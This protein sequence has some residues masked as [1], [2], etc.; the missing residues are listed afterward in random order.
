MKEFRHFL[1][2]IATFIMAAASCQQAPFLTMNSPKSFN[3][4]KDGGSQTFTF[5]TNK[6][7]KVSSSE[8]W[9][10]VSPSSGNAAEGN[11]TVTITAEKNNGY[12]SRS[13][14]LTVNVEDLSQTVEI[15]QSFSEEIIVDEKQVNVSWKPEKVIVNVQTNTDFEVDVPDPSWCTAERLST[16]GLT[17]AQISLSIKA[18]VGFSPRTQ[19]LTIKQKNGSIER[20]VSIN[21]G[22]QEEL[23]DMGLSV[24]WRSY[25][26]G[27]TNVIERGD[28]YAWGET[29]T[30][31]QYLEANYKWYK[32][33]DIK[34]VIKYNIANNPYIGEPEPDGKYILEPED[35]I[36]ALS[37]G[38]NWRMP[39]FFEALELANN[40]SCEFVENYYE[41]G[42]PGI[43]VTSRIEGYEE[44]SIF[45][46]L[47]G[48]YGKTLKHEDRE[49]QIWL[50]TQ[51]VKMA[52]L[53]KVLFGHISRTFLVV[54]GD[55]RDLGA[56]IRPIYDDK[57]HTLGIRINEN[58]YI[59]LLEGYDFQLSTSIYP[60][61][62]TDNAV[63]WSSAD[64]SIA[65]VNQ[66]GLVS[67]ISPGTV[68]ITASVSNGV[69][70]QRTFNIM[71]KQKEEYVDMGLSV[72]WATCNLGAD[73]FEKNGDY[74]SWG[75]TTPKSYYGWDNYAWG[76]Q[77]NDMTY[78]L[79]KYLTKEKYGS[80]DNLVQLQSQDD[81][82][83]TT[84]GNGWRMPTNKE[85]QELIDNSYVY[86][87]YNYYNT[88]IN[89]YSVVSKVEG[90]EDKSLFFPCAGYAIRDGHYLDDAS[91]LAATLDVDKNERAMTMDFYWPKLRS[92]VRSWGWPIRPVKNK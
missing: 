38:N 51:D 59:G 84:L 61:D 16:K 71:P 28:Y 39:T 18:N 3:F 75:E 83:V 6:D 54:G 43:I 53:A 77:N 29:E 45:F 91:Y 64:E 63:K 11:V 19:I 85:F 70:D 7:W 60:I 79:T 27:A 78:N 33:G 42:I 67:A 17:G 21:Q 12:D 36:A 46:P 47:T 31:E 87:M 69:Y 86:T 25:N 5:S 66:D 15:S 65:T 88:G 73:S 90:F 22:A 81:A 1:V 23:V 26:L 76:H 62:G 82:A 35:D 68:I 9:C 32:D 44:A 92:V 4:S 49:F 55:Y 52:S 2:L 37:L 58:D 89:G 72:L 10:K 40:S 50:S 34:Q 80:V 20:Q 8:S 30:K 14:T 24:K 74:Y 56:V 57:N 41:T 48:Y 13:C